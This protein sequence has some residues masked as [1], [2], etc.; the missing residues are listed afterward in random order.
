MSKCDLGGGREREGE[1]KGC[2]RRTKARRRGRRDG[3]G[4]RRT[5]G[6]WEGVR[7]RRGTGERVEERG[8]RREGGKKRKK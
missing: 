1:V 6:R 7:N 8:W 5:G 4:K 3:V 2:W